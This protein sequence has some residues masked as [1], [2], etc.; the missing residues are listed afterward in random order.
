[1]IWPFP[2]RKDPAAFLF[3]LLQY[4]PFLLFPSSLSLLASVAE[5][6]LHCLIGTNCKIASMTEALKKSQC[7]WSLVRRYCSPNRP[8]HHGIHAIRSLQ[9]A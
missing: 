2:F 8:V 5:P 6:L 7:T 1:M 9:E 4:A 3:P